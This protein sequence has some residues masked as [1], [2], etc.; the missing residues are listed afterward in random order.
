MHQAP[1]IP[2]K[3][4]NETLA[5][6]PWNPGLRSPVPLDLLK[7]STLY[8]EAN[9]RTT[10]ELARELSQ[11]TGLAPAELVVFTP[12]RLLTHELLIRVAADI[13]VPDGSGTDDL[14]VNFR[15]MV[16]TIAQRYV[17]PQL[18]PLVATFN[19]FR[20]ALH[21]RVHAELAATVYAGPRTPS[22]RTVRATT[23]VL[24]APPN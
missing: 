24:V 23:D 11:F 18:P 15:A 5:E 3:D 17:E 9:S 22:R 19:E 4:L 1:E 7:L 8:R 20:Q 6:G 21:A 16:S 12:E 13:R 2:D 10:V 14:G